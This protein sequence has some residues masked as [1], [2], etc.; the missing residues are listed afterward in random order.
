MHTH[1]IVI[2]A[3]Y[4]ASYMFSKYIHSH[5]VIALEIVDKYIFSITYN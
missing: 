1:S 4:T 5:I 2:C 3:D